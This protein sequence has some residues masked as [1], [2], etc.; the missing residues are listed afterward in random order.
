MRVG[1]VVTVAGTL[2]LG[3]CTSAATQ[4]FPTPGSYNPLAVTRPID[5]DAVAVGRELDKVERSIENGRDSGQLSS[6]EAR[7]FRKA[8]RALSGTAER[9]GA[10]GMTDGEKRDLENQARILDSQVQAAVI[11]GG[12]PKA[13]R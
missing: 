12:M 13:P 9:L 3:G 1:F 6:R 4:S 11:T 10:D 7:A 8:N 2:T 5:P